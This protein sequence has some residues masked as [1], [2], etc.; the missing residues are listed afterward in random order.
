MWGLAVTRCVRSGTRVN[1]TRCAVTTVTLRMVTCVSAGRTSPVSTVS[2]PWTSPA[3]RPGGVTPSVG[4]VTAP[5]TRDSPP[6]VT[7]QR[8]N[9]DAR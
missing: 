1:T 5:S 2:R 9:V 6:I 8:E 7:R 4:R 3:P